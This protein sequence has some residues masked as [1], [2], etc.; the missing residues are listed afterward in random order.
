MTNDELTRAE[1]RIMSLHQAVV[2]VDGE[3]ARLRAR[4]ADPRV[5]GPEYATLQQRR[6]TKIEE[7]NSLIASLQGAKAALK[8]HTRAFRAG[9]GALAEERR[10]ARPQCPD[11]PV[12][13]ALVGATGAEVARAL[14]G[15][16]TWVLRTA[17]M[18]PTGAN[19]A[20]LDAARD[21]LFAGGYTKEVAAREEGRLAVA[22]AAAL[23]EETRRLRRE[24]EQARAS[25]AE[26]TARNA[27]LRR[28]VKDLEEEAGI[29]RRY[30]RAWE[31]EDAG[32]LREEGR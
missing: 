24:M 14:F 13:T 32:L 19:A 5:K 30:K 22:K 2:A 3:L 18:V 4:M 9:L 16:A 15:L 12:A 7:K 20:T 1:A 10:A 25:A 31:E 23:E 26:T 6:T 17:E 8:G 11:N 21:Y 29:L 27:A 28:Q